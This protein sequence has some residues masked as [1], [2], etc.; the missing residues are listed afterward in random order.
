MRPVLRTIAGWG[1]D[2]A[3]Q[4]R[5]LLAAKAAVASALAWYLAPLIPFAEDEYSYYAPLGVLVSMYPTLARSARSG[6]LALVGLAIGIGI[7]LCGL[8]LVWADVPGVVAVALVV[9]AGVAL[10]GIR[11]LGAGRE[12]IAMAGLFT[13][14]LGGR[15]VEEF[16]ISYL[17]TMAFGVV[18]G[19]V[20]NLLIVPPLY[21]GR[22]SER[23]SFLRA[24]ITA[25]LRAI[26]DSLTEGG[27][28]SP[29]DVDRGLREL[30]DT[31]AAVAEVVREA[32]ESGR[33]NP[34]VRRHREERERN[35][36][37]MAALERTAFCTRDLAEVLLS[38]DPQLLS[39][40]EDL[41]QCLAEAVRATA[42]LVDTPEHDDDAPVR[43]AA[44]EQGLD[45]CF[46]RID[47]TP[48]PSPSAAAVVLAAATCVRRIID[49]SRPFV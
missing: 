39:E 6:A 22:A 31:G 37:R 2:I 29:E 42:D 44:A 26:A 10:G 14:L 24:T 3:D 43:L 35:E 1:R 33:A 23:L 15:S 17:V 11:A 46:A 4:P 34:R 40:H 25:Q 13:L 9:G 21:L 32:D 36:R 16:S 38:A 19:V 47:A 5:L 8:G 30:S 18:V 45:H 41:R 20:V 7:G 27:P 28:P 48:W 12:W 49:A